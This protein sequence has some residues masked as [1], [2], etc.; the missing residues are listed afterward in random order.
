MTSDSMRVP[1]TPSGRIHHQRGHILVV[2]Q[3]E[4]QRIAA[5]ECAPPT[6]H[7]VAFVIDVYA[8]RIAG[9]RVTGTM[10]TDFVIGALEQALYHR[11]PE[12][13]G[14]LVL[15]SDRGSQYVSIRDTEQLAEA[16]I[17]PS[18]GSKDKATTTPRPR[19]Q[20]AV[21]GCVDSLSGTLE[22][23]GIGGAVQPAVGVLV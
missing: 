18:M 9:W 17:E 12:R 23:Q 22:D 11:Q 10:R 1:P 5:G 21:Q 19:P 4:G 16:D 6:A 7:D 15:H 3:G 14:S 13:D 20:R 2:Q 8:R